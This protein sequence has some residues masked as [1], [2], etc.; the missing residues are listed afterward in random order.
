MKKTA[1]LLI[2]FSLNVML[3]GFPL[4]SHSADYEFEIISYPGC[5]YPDCTTGVVDINNLGQFVGVYSI[6]DPLKSENHFFLYDDGVY[7]TIDHPNGEVKMVGGI[8]WKKRSEQRSV[9]KY[10]K[11]TNCENPVKHSILARITLTTPE[12]SMMKKK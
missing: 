3:L 12:E 10:L 7:T 11:Y 1:L 4:F 5:D 2:I 6:F 9:R 8:K